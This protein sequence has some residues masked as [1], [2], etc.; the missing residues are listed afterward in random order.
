MIEDFKKAL[1]ASVGAT[2]ATKEKL[3]SVFSELVEKG[4]LSKDEAQKMLDDL[5]KDSKKEYE[6]AKDN[7]QGSIQSLINK[8]NFASQ[9]D[10]EALEKRVHALETKAKKH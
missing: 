9:Q 10:L 7:I 6:A 1:L 2:V 8:A 3:E 4:K 5:S